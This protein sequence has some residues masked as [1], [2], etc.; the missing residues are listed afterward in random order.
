M[1]LTMKIESFIAEIK[2]IVYL[3]SLKKYKEIESKKYNGRVQ[4]SDLERVIN[5]YGCEIIPLPD[6]AID[7]SESY[8]IESNN[9]LDVYLP[10]WTKE[11]GRSDL[12]LSVSCYI[13]DN[14]PFVE[15]DDLRVL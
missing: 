7:L 8:F 6:S 13:K 5:E 14:K 1:P 3:I 2:N 9:S 11:E 4:V 12:T 15:I 10:L